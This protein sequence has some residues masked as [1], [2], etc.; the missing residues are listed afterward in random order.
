MLTRYIFSGSFTLDMIGSAALG[1]EC[2]TFQQIENSPFRKFANLIFTKPVW[3]QIKT[4]LSNVFP[5]LCQALHFTIFPTE[6]KDFFNN[7]VLETVTYREKNN[8]ERNDFL[9]MMIQ[10]KNQRGEN[11]NEYIGKNFTFQIITTTFQR[12]F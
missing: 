9:Q 3:T 4:S 10:L 8:I 6:A 1:V 11:F 2:N 12:P 7:L 5:N